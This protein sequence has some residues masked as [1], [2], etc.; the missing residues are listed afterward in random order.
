M[1]FLFRYH[2]YLHFAGRGR[3]PPDWS[4]VGDELRICTYVDELRRVRMSAGG[5]LKHINAL[6]YAA[7]FASTRLR[8]TSRPR[9]HSFEFPVCP[10]TPGG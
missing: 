10:T 7:D 6:L 9:A 8:G 4:L 2:R 3:C 5:I 1:V